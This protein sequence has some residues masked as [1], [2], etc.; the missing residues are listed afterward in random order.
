MGAA[1]SPECLADTDIEIPAALGGAVTSRRAEFVAGRLCARD[2]LHGL[3]ATSTTVRR[4]DDRA[5][6][7]PA[8]FIGSISHS[9]DYAFAAV[10]RMS[11]ARSLGLDVEQ[12]ARLERAPQI[13]RVVTTPG[14]R[15]RFDFSAETL[16]IVFSGKEAI[17]KCLYPLL[18][19]F[20]EFD[21]IE[22]DAINPGGFSCHPTR[23]LSDEFHPGTTLT[24]RYVIQDGLI[25]TGVIL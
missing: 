5:P 25:H 4:G 12:I 21:A 6:E 1:V 9:G 8:G 18:R 22:F 2:A 13:T 11:D 20:L 3:G 14:E 17:Y 19:Q 7:W 15:A 16:A 24:G 10:A 23:R